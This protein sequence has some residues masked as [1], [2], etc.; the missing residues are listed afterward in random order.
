MNVYFVQFVYI[1][2]DTFYQP[3][4]F[5]IFIFSGFKLVFECFLL[6]IEF[7]NIRQMFVVV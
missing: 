3:N 4:D 1:V 2:I 7:I 6:T 5:S